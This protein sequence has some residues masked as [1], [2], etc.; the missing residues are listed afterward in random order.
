M[1][2]LKSVACLAAADGGN[3]KRQ[4]VMGDA[5]MDGFSD[6]GSI[7][8]RSTIY[9]EEKELVYSKVFL[10]CTSVLFITFLLYFHA[11]SNLPS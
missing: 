7:P 1:K 3:V 11:V 4:T 6:R 10:D 2:L 8:L 5:S 9:C